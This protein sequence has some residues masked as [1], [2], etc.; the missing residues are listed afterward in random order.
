MGLAEKVAHWAWELCLKRNTQP[1]LLERVRELRGYASSAVAEV[2][3][4]IG[5]PMYHA[6]NCSEHVAYHKLMLIK[7]DELFQSELQEQ[8]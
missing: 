7:I 6:E 8:K 3:G 4:H 5:D 2:G 1:N